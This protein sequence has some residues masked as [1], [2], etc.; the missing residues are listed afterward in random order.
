MLELTP[1]SKRT[2]VR[3][4]LR[5]VGSGTTQTYLIPGGA[6][7]ATRVLSFGLSFPF[8]TSTG[9]GV[10]IGRLIMNGGFGSVIIG[11]GTT[12]G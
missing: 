10:G 6:E 12:P 9:A 3:R 7:T 5:F 8:S 2:F 1:V 4:E 11:C